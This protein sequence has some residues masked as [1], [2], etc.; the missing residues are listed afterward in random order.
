M[1]EAQL[2]DVQAVVD[3]VV[4]AELFA[5]SETPLLRD[6]MRDYFEA[7]H[8]NGHRFV[9]DEQEDA[10]VG[11]AYYQPREAA[12]RVWDLTMI[13]VR[14]TEQ[15]SGR[16]VAVLSWVENDLR[17]H[18]QRL[19]MIETSATAQYD[20]A[21]SFY[22]KAGFD[23]EARVRDYWEDGDDLVIFRKSLAVDSAAGR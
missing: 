4:A 15:R 9:V 5:S 2:S 13:A 19:L 7:E 21:R 1:R 8:S 16:G 11:V 12:D 3:L 10:I 14:P 22:V 20:R 6:M 17:E 23:E 18:G